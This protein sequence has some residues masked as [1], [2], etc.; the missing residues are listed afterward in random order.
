M[1]I[2]K[3]LANAEIKLQMLKSNN[4]E[5]MLLEEFRH[6]LKTKNLTP[7]AFF[8]LSNKKMKPFISAEQFKL[9]VR[10]IKLDLS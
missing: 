7:L 2:K 10:E 3:N 9:S 8:R 4:A 1:N 6:Q 5:K